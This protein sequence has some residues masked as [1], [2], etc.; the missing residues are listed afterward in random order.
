MGKFTG[1]FAQEAEPAA[2][3]KFAGFFKQ[4]EEPDW[5]DQEAAET[6][7]ALGM[8][9]QQPKSNV[10]RGNILPIERNLDTGA[11]SPAV[12]ASVEDAYTLPGDVYSGQADLG[13]SDG[14]ERAF[15]LSMF[16]S[17]AGRGRPMPR[18]TRPDTMPKA[19]IRDQ[20]EL[21]STGGARMNE[22]K[23]AEGSVP[24]EGLR[25][26]MSDLNARMQEA[27]IRPNTKL[28]PQASQVYGRMLDLVRA[29]KGDPMMSKMPG[30]Q[31]PKLKDAT[32]QELHELRQMAQ[33]VQT[34]GWN[35]DLRQ[36]TA[37]GKLGAMMV[38]TVDDMIS[39]HPAAEQFMVGK[40]EYARGMKSKSVES[41]I[42][43]ASNTTQWDR[44]DHAGAIR[45][46]VNTFLKSRDARYLSPADIK[47][48]RRIKRYGFMD[49]LAGQGSLS[50]MALTIGRAVEAMTGLPPTS[51]FF[52]GKFA[53]DHINTQ[54]PKMLENMAARIRAG[55]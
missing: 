5:R 22:A 38:K 54:R 41:L 55:E 31:P 17:P 49:A 27:A 43:K 28:H 6:A 36:A 51:L 47:E 45:N 26:S 46:V 25:A 18:A 13:T 42:T 29:P 16:A 44:G 12:P 33:D 39:K 34:N 8:Q 52:A 14:Q 24:S 15:N 19:S 35:R 37:E 2:P 21:L 4:P 23:L 53:R 7:K 1:F 30:Y 40:G 32:M 50:P 10:V 48:L 3:N 11:M 9:L 20:A